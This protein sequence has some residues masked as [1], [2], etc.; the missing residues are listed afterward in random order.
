MMHDEPLPSKNLRRCPHVDLCRKLT[1]GGATQP[2]RVSYARGRVVPYRPTPIAEG[3]ARLPMTSAPVLRVRGGNGS[4]APSC[5]RRCRTGIGVCP[6]CVR[7][8]P[9]PFV[10]AYGECPS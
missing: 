2:A 5:H 6:T 8:D 9:A 4:A 3:V 7:D 1:T 10:C